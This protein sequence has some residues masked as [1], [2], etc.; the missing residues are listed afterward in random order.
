MSSTRV[1]WPDTNTL[2]RRLGSLDRAVLGIVSYLDELPPP[3]PGPRGPTGAQGIA[4]PT[5]PAGGPTGPTGPAGGPPGPTGPTG[6]TGAQGIAGPTGPTGDASGLLS[7]QRVSSSGPIALPATPLANVLIVT[8]AGAVAASLGPGASDGQRV[9]LIAASSAGTPF[10]PATITLTAVDGAG[11]P[12][13]SI[14]LSHRGAGVQ[15]VWD[16]ANATW[17]PMGVSY[18]P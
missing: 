14:Q 18:G 15:L 5:G 13:G 6:A 10:N 9:L 7:T 4:G 17:L 3:P 11:S 16:A 1:R 2:R 8:D 12:L